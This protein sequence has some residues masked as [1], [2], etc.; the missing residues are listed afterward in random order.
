MQGVIKP[1]Q[2]QLQLDYQETS[3]ERNSN[4]RSAV[5]ERLRHKTKSQMSTVTKQDSRHFQE[6][7]QFSKNPSSVFFKT[8]SKD[9][10][11]RTTIYST[12]RE[13]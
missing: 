12:K 7:K 3:P 5:L 2:Q 8:N 13:T 11:M 4:Q 10:R 9:D 1:R 6:E